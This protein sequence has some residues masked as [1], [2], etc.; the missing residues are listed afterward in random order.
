M[1]CIVILCFV[2]SYY[3]LYC[4]TMFCIVILLLAFFL[5]VYVCGSS[6]RTLVVILVSDIFVSR[7]GGRWNVIAFVRTR[8]RQQDAAKGALHGHL[9]KQR[10]SLG[11]EYSPEQLHQ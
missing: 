5:T 1:F 4:H 11:F 6:F 9:S 7:F 2:L 8:T 3:V 10:S